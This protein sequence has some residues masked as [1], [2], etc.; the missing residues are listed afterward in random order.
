MAGKD[1]LGVGVGFPFSL[2]GGRVGLA[3]YERSIQQSIWMILGTSPGERVMRPTFG[4][5]L[6]ELVFQPLNPQLVGSAVGAV[7]DAL[8]RWEPRISVDEVNAFVDPA[9][10]ATLNID[11]TYEVLATNSRQNL[12]YPFYLEH[13]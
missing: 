5:G 4:S 10:P 11:I 7:R 13:G 1:A 2:D 6:R 9:A 3:E 12:V 8:T